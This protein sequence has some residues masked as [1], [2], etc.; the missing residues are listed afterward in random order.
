MKRL[1]IINTILLAI[2]ASA[3]TWIAYQQSK[4]HLAFMNTIPEWA[5][6]S[7]TGLYYVWNPKDGVGLKQ[8][9]HKVLHLT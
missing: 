2:I 1:P 3:L 9:F 4:P 5:I 6:D 8:K 7:K